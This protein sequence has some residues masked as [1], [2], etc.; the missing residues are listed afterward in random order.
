MT[1]RRKWTVKESGRKGGIVRAE[2]L[3]AAA[4]SAIARLGGLAKREALR[5]QQAEPAKD[6]R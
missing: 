3:T 2:R 5:A 6:A 1:R 4:R